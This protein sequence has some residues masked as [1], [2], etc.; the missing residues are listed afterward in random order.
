MMGYPV[1]M[2]DT[3]RFKIQFQHLDRDLRRAALRTI[4]TELRAD[5]LSD[6][7]TTIH[8]IEQVIWLYMQHPKTHYKTVPSAKDR[9]KW[10]R[11][12]NRHSA[13]LAALLRTC[14]YGENFIHNATHL[15][16][17]DVTGNLDLLAKVFQ[18]SAHPTP[19]GL[20]RPREGFDWLVSGLASFFT[21]RRPDKT[22]AGYS[23]P[24]GFNPG[25]PFFRVVRAVCDLIGLEKEDEAILRQI[26]RVNL[27]THPPQ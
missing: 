17:S 21:S 19:K 11:A 23:R 15:C 8:H 27:I 20:G 5:R 1:V 12:V 4:F 14:P 7:R 3:P 6:C 24:G 10:V 13:E 26:S 16:V 22:V 2:P 25:G 9:A 18:A